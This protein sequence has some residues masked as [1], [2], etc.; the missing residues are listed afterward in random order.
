ML[1]ASSVT[2][3][4]T[5]TS[6][7]RIVS[8][9]AAWPERALRGQPAQGVQEPVGGR[10]QHQAELVG[11]RLAARDAVRGEGEIVG[12]HQIFR[13]AAST[14]QGLVEP[15]RRAGEVGHDEPAVH[16]VV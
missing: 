12:L 16:A 1:L 7:K 15:A 3:P 11:G 6:A 14:V 13:L 4:T 5:L 9:W 10:V 2:R 8:S